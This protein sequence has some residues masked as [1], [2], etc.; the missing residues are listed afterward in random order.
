MPSRRVADAE[1]LDAGQD[2]GGGPG[3]AERFGGQVVLVDEAADVGFERGDTLVNAAPDFFSV[4]RA[5]N[6]STWFS[7]DELV[8]LR[9]TCQRGRLTSQSRMIWVLWVA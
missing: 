8:G 1:A 6:R 2:I 7:H 4:I 3:P 5:K 9:C